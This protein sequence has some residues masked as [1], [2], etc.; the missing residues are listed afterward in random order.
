MD[1]IRASGLE[2]EPDALWRDDGE[3]H[4]HTSTRY[5]LDVRP[6]IHTHCFLP[7]AFIRS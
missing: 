5:H 7:F 3:V 1:S 6:Q 4:I 2:D